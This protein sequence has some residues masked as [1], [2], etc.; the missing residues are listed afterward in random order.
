MARCE[1]LWDCSKVVLYWDCRIATQRDFRLF[2][3]DRIGQ[4]AECFGH[5]SGVYYAMASYFAV[6]IGSH[7]H[8]LNLHFHLAQIPA[9]AILL[10][11]P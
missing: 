8:I 10:G 7:P 3:V 11:L 2:R 4:H 1:P 6:S 5:S 9:V